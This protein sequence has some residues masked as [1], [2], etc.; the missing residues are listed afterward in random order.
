MGL[1]FW[2]ANIDGAFILSTDVIA[3]VCIGIWD[4]TSEYGTYSM[5]DLYF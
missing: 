4:N 5:C 2:D 1:L 3:D